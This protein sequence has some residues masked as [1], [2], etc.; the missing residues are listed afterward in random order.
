M[1]FGTE[2]NRSAWERLTP[3]QK[4]AVEAIRAEHATPEYRAEEARIRED[5]RKEFPP[6]QADQPLL[7]VLAA[8]QRERER[9][10]LS[11]TDMMERTR[12]DRATINKLENGKIPNPTY[13]TMK[14][15]ARA[16]GLR[17]AWTLEPLPAKV[18]AKP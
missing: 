8:L 12:M 7:D 15:Y 11:L 9:Q 6:L 10:G 3:E 18:E 1:N 13:T 2:R 16:L 14:R 5:A 17:L 4:A